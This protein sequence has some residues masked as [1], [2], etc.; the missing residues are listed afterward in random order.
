MARTP[1]YALGYYRGLVI[2]VIAVTFV[3]FTS[4]VCYPCI[5]G[6]SCLH[7]VQVL[8]VPEHNPCQR[9]YNEYVSCQAIHIH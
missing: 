1:D 9:Q 5:I 4:F 7:Q 3:G 8:L 2:N 6:G